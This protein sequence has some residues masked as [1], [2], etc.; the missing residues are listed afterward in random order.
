MKPPRRFSNRMH[1]DPMQRIVQGIATNDRRGRR[2]IRLPGFDYSQEGSY[3]ITIVTKDRECLF[4]EVVGEEMRLTRIGQIASE[5]WREIPEHYPA[6]ELGEF[7]VMPNHLHG[8]I[9]IGKSVGAK[10]FSPLRE[11]GKTPFRSPSKTVGSIIRGFKIGV[12][13]WSRQNTD[14]H[15]IWQR[16]YYEHIVRDDED[17]NNITEYI[18][19]NPLQWSLDEENPKRTQA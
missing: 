13:K 10:D 19:N 1:S 7:V 3:F 8:I 15:D 5:C 4:G 16:N 18:L 6:V 9:G 17:L 11:K 14:A 2:S 12:T